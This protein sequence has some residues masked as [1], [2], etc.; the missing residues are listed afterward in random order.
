MQNV[1]TLKQII[2]K[3]VFSLLM[4]IFLFGISTANEK[5]NDN[6]ITNDSALACWSM[7][8]SYNPTTHNIN[9]TG[10]PSVLMAGGEYLDVAIWDM[11]GNLVY[12]IH[13]TFTANSAV[14]NKSQFTNNVCFGDVNGDQEYEVYVEWKANGCIMNSYNTNIY[15]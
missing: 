5:I 11:C 12:Y 13:K 2:I 7:G 9:V 8:F 3:K 1:K 10:S 15:F 6:L 4:V 14:I